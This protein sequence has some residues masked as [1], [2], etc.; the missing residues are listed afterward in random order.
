MN[1]KMKKYLLSLLIV[2]LLLLGGYSS[3][4]F[5]E[6]LDYNFQFSGLPSSFNSPIPLLDYE[7]IINTRPSDM[8]YIRFGWSSCTCE[9]AF[10]PNWSIV[11]GNSCSSSCSAGVYS[12]Y[13][14][15]GWD[16][17][18]LDFS[19]KG[20]NQIV[21]VD[22]FTPV[23]TGLTSSINE[24]VPYVVYIWIWV[25]GALIWFVAIKRLINRVRRKIFSSFK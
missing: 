11:K 3:A 5:S 24:F 20:V 16:C 23:I 25:L 1:I 19:L 8:C 4:Q 15:Q 9:V 18:S 12:V 10:V 17:W 22:N 6:N 14:A 7:F 2:P 21:S 13:E